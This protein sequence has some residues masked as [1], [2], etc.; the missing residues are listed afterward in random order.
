[1]CTTCPYFAEERYPELSRNSSKHPIRFVREY[2]MIR[3]RAQ[4]RSEITKVVCIVFSLFLITMP[5]DCFSADVPYQ[6]VIKQ[7]TDAIAKKNWDAAIKVVSALLA[8][9]PQDIPALMLR[10]RAYQNSHQSVAAIADLR[11]VLA[12]K[13]EN[14]DAWAMMADAYS[15]LGQRQEEALC[16]RVNL[17][18]TP[19]VQRRTEIEERLKTI[20]KSTRTVGQDGVLDRPLL[21][22]WVNGT[23]FLEKQKNLC[24]TTAMGKQQKGETAVYDET[25]KAIKNAQVLQDH[26]LAAQLY[27]ELIQR[28]PDNAQLYCDLAMTYAI[29]GKIP[30]AV[31]Q[32]EKAIEVK[33]DHVEAMLA[34]ADLNVINLNDS[35]K[36]LY[37][38]TL[39]VKNEKDPSKK[40]DIA[41]RMRKF[42]T[43]Q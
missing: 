23:E 36:A 9:E 29:L 39:A 12:L 33:P 8:K 15:R 30:E 34:L 17:S 7:T 19:D 26:E 42:L 38:Y 5:A 14:A 20:E 18:L 3:Q 4:M 43:R 37:W 25:Q 41:G 16:L 1:M 22:N 21:R 13:P 35:K 27:A 10:A 2:D 32:Y 24:L 28:E 31:K 11:K 40:K 6:A